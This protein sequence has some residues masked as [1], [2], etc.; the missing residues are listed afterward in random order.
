M[1]VEKFQIDG[2]L[3]LA[4]RIFEDNRGHFFESYN[5]LRFM[6]VGVTDDFVQ[7]N[8]SIS[9]KNVLRGLH[10]QCPP[11]AQAKLIRVVQGSVLDVV[12]DLRNSSPSYGKHISFELTANKVQYLY[13]PV[14]FA[15]GF[16]TLEDN[17]IFQYKC[18]EYYKKEA[19]SGIVW[20]DAD[21]AIAW[22]ISNPLLSEKDLDLPLFSKMVKVF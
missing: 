3:L 1:L 18:S 20:N 11:Y 4:P 16:L 14:G 6:E 10:F 21:L 9:Q 12:V 7:D 19:E 8:E 13:I 15:H 2:L 5:K 22:K 17:T